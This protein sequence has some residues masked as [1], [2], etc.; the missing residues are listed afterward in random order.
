MGNSFCAERGQ[1]T[2]VFILI[3]AVREASKK[4]REDHTVR[5]HREDD[6]EPSHQ[7]RVMIV[8]QGRCTAFP[9]RGSQRLDDY[10]EQS[11]HPAQANRQEPTT[12]SLAGCANA[13]CELRREPLPRYRTM[14]HPRPLVTVR[15][16]PFQALVG[17]AHREF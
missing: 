10:R 4:I 14:H 11:T 3:R 2:V 17:W 13:V 7:F 12:A 1:H 6:P 15:A 9:K 8:E 16:L 5:R